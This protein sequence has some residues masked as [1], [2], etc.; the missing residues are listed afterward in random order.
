MEISYTGEVGYSGWDGG[1]LVSARPGD[2]IDVSD[3]KAAQLAADFPDAWR[4]GGGEPEGEL[5]D[6]KRGE[7]DDLA[8]GLGIVAPGKLPNIAAVVAAINAKRDG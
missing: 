8:S 7:L 2:T 5:S 1:V 4:T 3:A 6:M